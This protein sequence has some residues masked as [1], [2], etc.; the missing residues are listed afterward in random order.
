MLGGGDGPW[1]QKGGQG[2]GPRGSPLDLLH[3]F[4]R[5]PSEAKCLRTETGR[6]REE[7]TICSVRATWGLFFLVFVF[8]PERERRKPARGASVLSG[9]K[10]KSEA[11]ASPPVYLL[12][13]PAPLQWG[14]SWPL[15]GAPKEPPVTSFYPWSLGFVGVFFSFRDLSPRQ[16]QLARGGSRREERMMDR[17][18]CRSVGQTCPSQGAPVLGFVWGQGRPNPSWLFEDRARPSIRFDMDSAWGQS[19]PLAKKLWEGNL[20]GYAW[21]RRKG[22][23]LAPASS[24][25]S[26][27]AL[28]RPGLPGRP[29]E[30]LARRLAM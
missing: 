3:R 16:H 23:G 20:V 28:F 12:P 24:L 5:L 7:N 6:E 19:L 27:F 22:A 18:G 11:R 14:P 13:W 30:Y 29:V 15:T 9:Q 8:R 26:G 2:K 4:R 1:R 21:L 25:P 17:P 10:V